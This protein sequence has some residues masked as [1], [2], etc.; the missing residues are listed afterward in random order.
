MEFD[1]MREL[2]IYTDK[3]RADIYWERQP[4]TVSYPVPADR[5]L[6]RSRFQAYS[7]CDFIWQYQRLDAAVPNRKQRHDP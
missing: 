4:W 6:T 7:I 5:M 2:Q 3:K 1:T